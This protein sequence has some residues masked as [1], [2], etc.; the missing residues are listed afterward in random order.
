MT[1]HHDLAGARDLPALHREQE[2]TDPLSVLKGF[3]GRTSGS[4]A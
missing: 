4:L 1:L 3:S 2:L